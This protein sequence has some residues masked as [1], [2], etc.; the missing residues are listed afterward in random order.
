[1]EAILRDNMFLIILIAIAEVLVINYV[2]LIG[3]E[4]EIV[5]S[6]PASKIV[7]KKEEKEEEVLQCYAAVK[8]K[9]FILSSNRQQCNNWRKMHRLPM[10]RKFVRSRW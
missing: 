6:K 8:N 2:N 10:R 4:E 5:E 7:M 1:M 9:N 3:R